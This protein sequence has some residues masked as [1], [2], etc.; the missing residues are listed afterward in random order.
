[1]KDIL[2]KDRKISNFDQYI[3][4]INIDYINNYFSL[5]EA[6]KTRLKRVLKFKVGL[7]TEA[8][9]KKEDKAFV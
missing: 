9:L 7:M 1:M 5:S 6:G 8:D 4:K 2:E 3:N